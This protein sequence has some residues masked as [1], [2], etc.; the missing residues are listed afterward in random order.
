MQACDSPVSQA[1]I[2]TLQDRGMT[3]RNADLS[4]VSRHRICTASLELCKH[5]GPGAERRLNPP[6]LPTLT[7]D[8]RAP[9]ERTLIKMIQLR[10]E[11]PVLGPI[12]D[13][14]RSPRTER[15]CGNAMRRGVGAHCV[16]VAVRRPRASPVIAG[17]RRMSAIQAGIGGRMLKLKNVPVAGVHNAH[18]AR[19]PASH[20]RAGAAENSALAGAR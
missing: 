1:C 7:P 9:G 8:P 13:I 18:I 14:F 12:E 4:G 19:E 17:L 11:L 10:G 6:L 15:G 16:T 20:A 5:R 3:M 2:A